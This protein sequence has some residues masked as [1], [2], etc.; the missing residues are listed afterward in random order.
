MSTTTSAPTPKPAK[1]ITAEA[2]LSFPNLFTPHKM[3]GSN[4]E[5]KY[6]CVLLFPKATDLSAL[7]AE[8]SRAIREKW[9]DKKP[10]NLRS[11]FR[12]G[13]EKELDG[14]AGCIYIRVSSKQ[15]PGI[16]DENVQ[17]IIDPAAIYAGCYVRAS[18][19]AYAY[20]SNGNRGVAFGLQNIQKVR[21]GA[22]F[23]GGSRAEDD[24]EAV[25]GAAAKPVSGTA[26]D[27]FPL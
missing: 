23:G 7:K 18:V 1:L 9:G 19:R 26:D 27:D 3:E 24:F 4:G 11:P 12:D 5:P 8:A 10:A 15:K 2:R 20:D 13:D 6:D 14:Y 16:V 17:P 25:A 22:P 21:D